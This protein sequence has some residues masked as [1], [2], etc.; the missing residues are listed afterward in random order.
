[1][2][3]LVL[4]QHFILEFFDDYCFDFVTMCRFLLAGLLLAIEVLAVVFGGWSGVGGISDWTKVPSTI[5]VIIFSLVFHDLAPC[6]N[7]TL[8]L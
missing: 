8:F 7:E 4:C 2:F 5:P 1:M 6:E 3:S